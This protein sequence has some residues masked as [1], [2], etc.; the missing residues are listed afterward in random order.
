MIKNQNRSRWFGASD[1]SIIM[2]NWDTETFKNWWAIKLGFKDKGASSWIMDCG[3]IME[4]PIIR[5]IEKQ[6]GKKIKIGRHPYYKLS[7]RLRVN[8]DGLRKDEVVEIKTTENIW[9][10]IPKKY[11]QQCQVLMWK[12][13]KVKTGLYIYQMEKTDYLRPYFPD[14]DPKRL[15]R[16]EI[17]YDESFINNE[18][19]PRLKYLASCLRAKKF[20]KVEEYEQ[21]FGKAS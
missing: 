20:P 21:V 3:N 9:K 18:Y 7:L 4:I 13:R 17:E 2:G 14:I 19:L 11:W 6:E 15:T 12:K 16:R 1:T 8:Y 10:S 5:F